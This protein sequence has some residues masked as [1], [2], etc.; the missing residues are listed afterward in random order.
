MYTKNASNNRNTG[1]E[2]TYIVSNF[3]NQSQKD[4]KT[5]A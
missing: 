1:Y 5:T 2:M 3:F 4:K